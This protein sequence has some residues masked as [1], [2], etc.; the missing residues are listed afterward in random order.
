MALISCPEYLCQ[1]SSLAHACPQCGCPIG[2][3]AKEKAATGVPVVTVQKVSKKF[4]AH[5]MF[6]LGLF[7]VGLA[8]TFYAVHTMDEWIRDS[9]YL[10]AFPIGLMVFA[11]AWH[12]L[13]ELRTWWHH[14]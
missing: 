12:Y 6:S 5:G 7:F 2:A 13:N 1:V 14:G 10:L 8:L 4:K 9:P 11:L 3:T